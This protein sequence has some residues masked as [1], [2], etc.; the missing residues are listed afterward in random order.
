MS[1]SEVRDLLGALGLIVTGIVLGLVAWLYYPLGTVARMGPGFFPLALAMLL[2]LLGVMLLVSALV[3]LRQDKELELAPPLEGRS[4][5]SVLA[6]ILAFAATARTLG[7]VPA[8]FL[9]IL[10]ATALDRTLTWLERAGIAVALSLLA[11]VVFR[12]MLG[13][14]F[15]AFR[16]P[17]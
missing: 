9:T 2:S 11:Y 17:L 12:W 8:I 3:R 4:M 14:Q 10:I 15:I 1:H 5:I 13:L 7:Q 6:A 16:W